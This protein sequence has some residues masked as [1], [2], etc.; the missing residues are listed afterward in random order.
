L[1]GIEYSKFATFIKQTNIANQQPVNN[2]TGKQSPAGRLREKIS[3]YQS[4]Y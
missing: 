2:E 4:N 3:A 1:A